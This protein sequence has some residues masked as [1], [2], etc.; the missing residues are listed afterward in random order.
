[1]CGYG[2]WV[3]FQS[4][5][6]A[7]AFS[8]TLLYIYPGRNKNMNIYAMTYEEPA[9]QLDHEKARFDF[10]SGTALRSEVVALLV[11]R[12]LRLCGRRKNKRCGRLGQQPIGP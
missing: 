4:E 6:T 12:P 8:L 5:F 7:S 11:N 10:A 1:M 9:G 2:A 3:F